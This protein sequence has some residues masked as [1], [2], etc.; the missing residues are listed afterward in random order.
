M[1]GSNS[2][3]GGSEGELR[4][5]PP[6]WWGLFWGVVFF[7]KRQTPRQKETKKGGGGSTMPWNRK[8]QEKG[9]PGPCFS[10]VHTRLT[11]IKKLKLINQTAFNLL[12]TEY[13]Q[14][15]HHQSSINLQSINLN[16]ILV[17]NSVTQQRYCN[18]VCVSSSGLCFSAHVYSAQWRGLS[19]SHFEKTGFVEP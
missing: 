3:A 7:L 6:C 18:A 4:V 14:H 10:F 5:V 9:G 15:H 19:E 16:R 12:L 1:P 17:N 11:R 8:R 13:R 2:K